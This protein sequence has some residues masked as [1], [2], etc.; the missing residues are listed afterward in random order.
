MEEKDKDIKTFNQAKKFIEEIV[1]PIMVDFEKFKRMSNY[2]AVSIEEAGLLNEEIRDINRI[3]GAK[4]MCETCL[5]LID[6]ISSVVILKG[7]KEEISML[8]NLSNKLDT[9]KELFYENKENFYTKE[10]KG[11][12]II[13]TINRKYFEDIRKLIVICKTNTDILQHKNKLL[14]SDSKDEFASDEEIKEQIMKDFV[15]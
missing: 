12:S 5:D 10:Y 14:F 2:G 3:N 7:N 8:N 9:I 6:I 13:E 11:T 1:H 4:G 15:D